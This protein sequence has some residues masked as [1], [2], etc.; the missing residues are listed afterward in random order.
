[1]KT[2]FRITL[3]IASSLVLTACPEHHHYRPVRTYHRPYKAAPSVHSDSSID[4]QAVEKPG[5]YSQ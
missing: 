5:S 1:M 2:F 4:F 3:L